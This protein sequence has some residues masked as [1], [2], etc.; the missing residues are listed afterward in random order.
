[1]N[2]SG[3]Q[4]FYFFYCD[5]GKVL[6]AQ[7]KIVSQVYSWIFL[8]EM[9]IGSYTH[10]LPIFN[11][12]MLNRD[13]KT[14]LKDWSLLI[15]SQIFSFPNSQESPGLYLF[16]V[17][18]PLFGMFTPFPTFLEYFRGCWS[19]FPCENSFFCSLAFHII[20]PSFWLP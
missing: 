7:I 8:S 6:L 3:T 19:Y 4:W 13:D 15:S 12:T 2:H 18:D 20:V 17:L 10:L 5:K 11:A 14:K 1:M 9:Q 16:W